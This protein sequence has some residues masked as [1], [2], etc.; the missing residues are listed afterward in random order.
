M[1][2]TRPRIAIVAVLSAAAAAAAIAPAAA[3]A[4][5]IA[6][7]SFHDGA[8]RVYAV[9]P[10]GSGRHPLTTTPGAAFE[11]SPA[12][13]PDGR[14]IAYTCGNFELCLMNADGSA[15]MRLTTGAWPQELRYDSDPAWSP[16]GTKIVFQRTV[17]RQDAIFVVNVDG[18]GLR[19]I[20]VPAG[21]N[22]S[23][24]FSP[25]GTT[26]A[27]DH[28]DVSDEDSFS[29]EPSRIY[30]VGADGAGLRLVP[31][32]GAASD[33]AWS[34]DGRR[35]A[36]V[37]EYEDVGNRITVINA[38]GTGRAMLTRSE[39]GNAGSPA[40][41]PDGSRIVFALVGQRTSSL[42]VVAAAGGQPA[43]L[44]S[45]NGMD[46]EPTWQ[47]AGPP[48]TAAAPSPALPPSQATPD[49]RA[50]GLLAETDARFVLALDDL[51]SQSA[52]ELLRMSQRI[53]RVAKR[54][55]SAARRLRPT[56]TAGKHVLSG[57][58]GMAD[59]M[60]EMATSM[61]AWSRSAR[62]HRRAAARQHRADTVLSLLFIALQEIDAAKAAGASVA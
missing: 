8:A 61:R 4:Q 14:R 60:R 41:S 44:T 40:W 46:G 12:Y 29:S 26:I 22:S 54:V 33:P 36:Y 13:S 18:S 11:G 2:R 31:G 17:A 28:T 57:I 51:S 43:R 16:D 6:F 19:Q 32:T 56:T 9:N 15:Q 59:G 25:D 38:D 24:S 35:I 21:V 48:R 53:D 23:P 37:R 49:A 42:Y 34:P 30:L 47:P 1:P 3:S 20:P 39:L 62:R 55:S 27:F 45:R 7:T 5:T 50:V 52:A 10:D 58:G